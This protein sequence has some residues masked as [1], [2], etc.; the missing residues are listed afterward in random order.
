[1]LLHWGLN[2]I[3]YWISM[4][5]SYG[6]W[7]L[8]CTSSLPLI[9]LFPSWREGENITVIRR[10][11]NNKKVWKITR[12]VFSPLLPKCCSISSIIWL[13]GKIVGLSFAPSISRRSEQEI[14]DK[15]FFLTQSVSEF[16][17]LDPVYGSSG[18]SSRGEEHLDVTW[19]IEMNLW[20]KVGTN[21]LPI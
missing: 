15:A 11:K 2:S 21:K 20:A 14:Q 3:I 18:T 6:S 16:N 12:K 5:N 13:S 1:M 4:E 17:Y 9:I 7:F 8:K 10:K 19:I